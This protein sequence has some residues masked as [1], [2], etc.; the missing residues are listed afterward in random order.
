MAGLTLSY[1]ILER[2]LWGPSSKWFSGVRHQRAESLAFD[3]RSLSLPLSLNLS[4]VPFISVSL[5]WQEGYFSRT[6]FFSRGDIETSYFLSSKE[7]DF[8][9]TLS[10]SS[11][12]PSRSFPFLTT[13]TPRRRA[14][15]VALVAVAPCNG[16]GRGR[17]LLALGKFL[18]GKRRAERRSSRYI[19]S[20]IGRR[21]KT[22]ARE[23]SPRTV[24]R[25]ETIVMSSSRTPRRASSPPSAAAAAAA[26]SSSSSHSGRY[27]QVGNPSSI[28]RLPKPQVKLLKKT[29]SVKQLYNSVLH[30]L[31]TIAHSRDDVSP[32]LTKTFFET[33]LRTSESPQLAVAKVKVSHLS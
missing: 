11:F 22:R 4:R 24:S 31:K 14:R 12:S 27:L 13:T 7:R 16:R 3:F 17:P 19:G 10:S 28:F 21:W 33:V 23:S 29:A 5:Q 18:A 32:E 9:S 2:E 6:L 15:A 1:S 30:A 8:S 20:Q 26:A 25:R